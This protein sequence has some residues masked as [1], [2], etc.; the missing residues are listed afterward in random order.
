M[1]HKFKVSAPKTGQSTFFTTRKSADTD[2]VESNAVQYVFND[3]KSKTEIIFSKN[4]GAKRNSSTLPPNLSLTSPDP[5]SAYKEEDSSDPESRPGSAA[6]ETSNV[7]VIV[8]IIEIR[9]FKKIYRQ[10]I[11]VILVTYWL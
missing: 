5:L 11:S 9:F 2:E 7:P 6:D 8:T 1:S 10:L 3:L 4:R